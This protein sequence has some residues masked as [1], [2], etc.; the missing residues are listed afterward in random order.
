MRGNKKEAKC[1]R[2]TKNRS[3]KGCKCDTMTAVLSGSHKHNSPMTEF[4][5]DFIGHFMSPGAKDI[6]QYSHQ[7]R[8]LSSAYFRRKEVKPVEKS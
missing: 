5:H 8:C 2:M 7:R 6:V 1:F 4:S 3:K